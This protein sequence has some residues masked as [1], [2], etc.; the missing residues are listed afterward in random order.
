V[1]GGKT[2]IGK[3]NE[4]AHRCRLFEISVT[5]LVGG[6]ERKRRNGNKLSR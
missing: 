4:G 2:T 3:K 1:I 6:E 5:V